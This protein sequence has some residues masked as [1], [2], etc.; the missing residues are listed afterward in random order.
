MGIG[1]IN[2]STTIAP[3]TGNEFGT[4]LAGDDGVSVVLG[5][6]MRYLQGVSR[7]CGVHMLLPRRGALEK[8]YFETA[9][10]E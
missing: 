8:F 7:S 9:S 5:I 3:L 10:R 4:L 6:G 2:R 1:R